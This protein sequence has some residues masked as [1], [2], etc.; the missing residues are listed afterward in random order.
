M[1]LQAA[2]TLSM[3]SGLSSLYLLLQTIFKDKV[4]PVR[5]QT[6]L[7][8][9]MRIMVSA[10]TSACLVSLEWWL[11]R[12]FEGVYYKKS[13]V[14]GHHVMLHNLCRRAP[15]LVISQVLTQSEIIPGESQSLLGRNLSAASVVIYSDLFWLIV[16]LRLL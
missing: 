13:C 11:E 8:K 3:G 14:K 4:K 15:S 12:G 5:P 9:L 10:L 2:P 7:G 16:L 1:E 6:N